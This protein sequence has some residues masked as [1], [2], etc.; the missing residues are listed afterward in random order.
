MALPSNKAPG[1]D[2]FTIEFFTTSWDLVG[3]DLVEAVQEFFVNGTLHRQVN[4][5]VIALIS[6]FP[7]ASS[8]KEFRPISLCNTVYK[9]ISR[10]LANR[11]KLFIGDAVQRNQAGFINGR[12]LCENVLL[13]SELVKDFNKP[14][15]TS[16]GCLQI[17]ITKV[18]DNVN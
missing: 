13:A 5:T 15:S 18:Y 10:L 9:I 16:R 6:K 3:S 14:G 1:P 11:L 2:G 4:A 12:L 8:L 17:D 7:G